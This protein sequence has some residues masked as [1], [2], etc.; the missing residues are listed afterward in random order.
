WT[1]ADSGANWTQMP[2]GSWSDFSSLSG[3]GIATSLAATPDDQTLTLATTTGI[4][5][6]S[7]TTGRWKASN[8]TGTGAPGGGFSYVG[9]TTNTQGVA[10][11]ADTSLHEIWM[12]FDGG[13]TW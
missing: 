4:Y 2:A 13:T 5:V 9:M 10:L 7:G 12:T 11:P 3:I 1:S 8:V 6:L